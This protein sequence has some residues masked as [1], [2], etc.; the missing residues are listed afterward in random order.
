M[1]D[2]ADEPDR[3]D[4]LAE[5]YQ[6]FRLRTAPTWAHLIGDYRYAD[7][8][9]AVGRAAEEAAAAQ[10]RGFADQADALDPGALDDQRR[11]TRSMVAWDASARAGMLDS[12]TSE[13]AANPIFGVQASIGVH[14]PKLAVPD[15]DV[16]EAMV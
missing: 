9:E 13:L 1:T 3:L 15:A 10:A 5:D 16:A 12:R 11:I 7:R 4:R 6:D 2:Q 14:V 8:F